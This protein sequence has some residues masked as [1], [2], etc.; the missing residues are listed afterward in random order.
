MR[1]EFLVEPELEFGGGGRHIDI[2]YGLAAFGPFDVTAAGRPKEVTIGLVGTPES[3]ESVKTWLEGCSK[4]VTAKASRL[5]HLYPAFPGFSKESP[6]GADLL[7]PDGRTRQI[8]SRVVTETIAEGD[9]TRIVE[10]AVSVFL[11]ECA[12]IVENHQA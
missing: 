12:H 4:G 6:F 9:R 11:E 5:R 8:T 3:T 2:R 1:A 7:F 10:R